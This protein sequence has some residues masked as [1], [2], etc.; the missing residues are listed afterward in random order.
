[1]R[2]Q[3][4]ELTGVEL[5]TANALIAETEEAGLQQGGAVAKQKKRQSKSLCRKK[6]L[7]TS[8]LN[9]LKRKKMLWLHQKKRARKY[10]FWTSMTV[11]ILLK[12]SSETVSHRSSKLVVFALRS[13]PRHDHA[14]DRA[15]LA[16]RSKKAI[17]VNK[18]VFPGTFF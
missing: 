7:K 18:F 15:D 13:M 12:R 14:A 9:Q 4:K 8:W 3:F 2:I 5:T 16:A 17:S 6:K 10:M 1:M 11:Q